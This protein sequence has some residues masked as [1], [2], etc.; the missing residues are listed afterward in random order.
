MGYKNIYLVGC[1]ARYGTEH[2]GKLISKSNNDS[3]HFRPDYFGTNIEFGGPQKHAYLDRWN[4]F[5]FTSSLC[6]INIISC[7][8]NSE[9]HKFGYKYEDI[10]TVIT[11][12]KEAK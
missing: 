6:P 9:L 11:K 1:D 10:N 3:D 8:K 2:I 7:T 4:Q 12:I 5:P